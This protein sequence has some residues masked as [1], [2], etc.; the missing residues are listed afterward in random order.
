M[1]ISYC[2][3][4]ALLLSVSTQAQT[5]GDPVDCKVSTELVAIYGGNASCQVMVAGRFYTVRQFVHDT[6]VPSQWISEALVVNGVRGN[7]SCLASLDKLRDEPRTR[8]EC[9]YKPVA[10]F[11]ITPLHSTFRLTS[12]SGDADGYLVQYQW[13]VD[14]VPISNAAT[15]ELP[16]NNAYYDSIGRSYSRYQV[17]L[18]VTDN[19]GYQTT[20]SQTLAELN[21]ECRT[22]ACRNR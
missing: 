20:Y 22:Q 7:Y 9:K 3:P 6:N 16:H 13:V 15:L 17:S 11:S 5:G 18:T 4:L 19:H 12:T 2:L 21:D 14:G 1:K 8:Q 10:G